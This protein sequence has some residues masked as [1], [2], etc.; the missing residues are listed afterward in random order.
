MMKFQKLQHYIEIAKGKRYK[1]NNIHTFW[2]IIWSIFLV[3]S[4]I[5]LIWAFIFYN[6]IRTGE[7]YKISAE[8][9]EKNGF[10]DRAEMKKLI[11]KYENRRLLFNNLLESKERYSDPAL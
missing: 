2:A 6:K 8:S 5:I 7:L 3:G 10:I 11:E 4:V 9:S 1:L